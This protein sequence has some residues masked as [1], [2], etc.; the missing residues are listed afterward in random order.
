MASTLITELE[1][2]A[3]ALPDHDRHVRALAARLRA[4]IEHVRRALEPYSGAVAATVMW[5]TSDYE[6]HRGDNMPETLERIREAICGPIPSGSPG[7]GESTLGAAL[8]RCMHGKALRDHSGE[9]LEP[10]CGCRAETPEGKGGE[11]G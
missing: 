4:R 2:A 1:Q 5:S 8:P 9:V 6:T 11:H 7:T 3:K 10:A